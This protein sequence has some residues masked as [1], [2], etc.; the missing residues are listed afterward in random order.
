MGRGQSSTWERM[1][2]RGRRE[3]K[4]EESAEQGRGGAEERVVTVQQHPAAC[5]SKRNTRWGTATEEATQSASSVCGSR[6]RGCG[7]GAIVGWGPMIC[8]EGWVNGTR[9]MAN[10][11][12]GLY[13][14]GLQVGEG[15]HGAPVPG[16]AS[17]YAVFADPPE[18][19]RQR[20]GITTAVRD[21]CTSAFKQRL[22]R[23][24]PGPTP[25]RTPTPRMMWADTLGI[26]CSQFA[27]LCHG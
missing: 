21:R 6:I 8:M 24:L 20:V 17:R 19:V 11:G 2:L 26:V 1:Q 12:I 13:K 14:S 3:R 23:P 22:F 25:S 5:T 16:Q 15:R 9:D 18:I 4:E 27:E 7:S 10:R